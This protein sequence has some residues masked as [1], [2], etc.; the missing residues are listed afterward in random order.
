MKTTL[1]EQYVTPSME[2]IKMEAEGG[3]M[4]GS[5]DGVGDGGETFANNH[6]GRSGSYCNGASTCE[7][8]DLI[9]DI[10]TIGKC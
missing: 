1:K 8:E 4:R 10:L 3:V 5:M 7:P 9:N 2:V 6:R